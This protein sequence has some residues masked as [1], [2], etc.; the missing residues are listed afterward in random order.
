MH[1]SRGTPSDEDIE[2]LGNHGVGLLH[3]PS[4][5]MFLGDGAAPLMKMM[6]AGMRPALG[7]DG[8]CSNNRVSVLK[9]CE[10]PLSFK[11]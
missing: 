7:S 4:S 11:K 8:G 1:C 9:R 5:N 3:C 10:W 6:A 2:I